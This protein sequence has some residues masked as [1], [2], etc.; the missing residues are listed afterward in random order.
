LLLTVTLL[1]ARAVGAVYILGA[2]V[3]ALTSRPDPLPAV[4]GYHDLF[5]PR[6]W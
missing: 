2:V 4:F 3:Y 5:T 1:A 6:R